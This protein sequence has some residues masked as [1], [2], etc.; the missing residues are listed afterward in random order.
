MNKMDRWSYQINRIEYVK[1]DLTFTDHKCSH[2]PL[3]ERQ[4]SYPKLKIKK[5]KFNRG[6]NRKSGRKLRFS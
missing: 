1:S 2:F 3:Q 5:L 6:L 4:Y